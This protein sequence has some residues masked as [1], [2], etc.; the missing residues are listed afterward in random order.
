MEL[1]Q[2]Y[3]LPI[4]AFMGAL[5]TFFTG[6]GLNTILV[7]IFL[8]YVEPTLA[9][10]FAGLVHLSNNVL[11]VGLT[12]RKIDWSLFK[13]FG[14]PALIGAALGASLLVQVGGSFHEFLKPIFGVLFML[15][16]ILEFF[17]WRFARF[18]SV[19]LNLG[20]F[21]SG[22]FGGFSGHQGALR[23]IFLSQ[24]KLDRLLFVATTA[25][26]SLFVDLTRIGFYMQN[27]KI[28]ASIQWDLM[29]LTTVAAFLGTL[30]GR[31]L[32]PQIKNQF[33]DLLFGLALFSLGLSM[34]LGWA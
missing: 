30:V 3:L 26:I 34:L 28:W 13:S 2:L 1:A 31:Y 10:F 24:L 6:F 22:F 19:Q 20:G 25:L 8:W 7:P 27:P 15:F 23:A 18:S 16:A 11:K 33:F 32:L 17:N 12:A 14:I 9:V 21:L 29:G 5:A 4:A